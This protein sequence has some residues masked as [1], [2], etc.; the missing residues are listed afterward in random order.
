MNSANANDP[1]RSPASKIILGEKRPYA[2]SAVDKKQLNPAKMALNGFSTWITLQGEFS[3]D[4]TSM[5]KTF[6]VYQDSDIFSPSDDFF[7]Q[8]TT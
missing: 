8:A 6:K 4:A 5:L 7:I 3:V 1:E 2:N